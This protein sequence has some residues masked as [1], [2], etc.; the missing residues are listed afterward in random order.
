MEI[1]PRPLA[2]EA[3]RASLQANHPRRR[4][5]GART[6]PANQPRESAR[7]RLR[8]SQQPNRD[9]PARGAAPPDPTPFQPERPRAPRFDVLERMT[10][11]TWN[12]H[13]S[14]VNPAN[15]PGCV[16][17]RRSAVASERPSR[18]RPCRRP[19][20]HR[21]G[22]RAS[23]LAAAVAPTGPPGPPAA[24]TTSHAVNPEFGYVRAGREATAPPDRASTPL[25]SQRSRRR[26]AT[27]PQLATPTAY[28]P[29]ASPRSTP[30]SWSA[31]THRRPLRRSQP[32]R[33]ESLAPTA[34][35]HTMGDA[36]PT[37]RPVPTLSTPPGAA[38]ATTGHHEPGSLVAGAAR[39]TARTA[40]ARAAT[41]RPP[42]TSRRRIQTLHAFPHQPG[43]RSTW[44]TSTPGPHP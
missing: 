33:P 30:D 19:G 1:L 36:P 6:V 10:C 22:A 12:S 31:S 41:G 29:P 35:N 26:P 16:R 11:S 20:T 2:T 38:P 13:G 21:N 8:R 24:C 23:I 25:Q 28:L 27:I 39:P 18:A 17:P 5:T 4:G 40:E 9:P 14:L 7:P 32:T 37:Q 3:G 42:S 44:N 43:R 15:Q 34:P